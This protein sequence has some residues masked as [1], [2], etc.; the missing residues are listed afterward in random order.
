MIKNIR[1]LT[2]A[3]AI[4]MLAG[5]ATQPPA[6]VVNGRA[7]QRSSAYSYTPPAVSSQTTKPSM[8]I[9][10][11]G[12]TLSGIADKYNMTVD[13]L[14][15]ANNLSSPD[16]LRLGQKLKIEKPVKH[17]SLTRREIQEPLT[18][19]AEEV[20]PAAAQSGGAVSYTHHKVN[21]GENLFR[22]GL[23]YGVSPLDI[24][25]ENDIQTPE[26]LKAGTVL[27]IPV[28]VTKGV[29][30]SDERAIVKIN[31][32][33]AK[34]KGFIWP[35]R[36]KVLEGFGPKSA[37]IA[38]TGIKILVPENTQV[39]AAEQGTVIYADNGLSSY[40]N[41]ILLR[42]NN[43]LITAYAHNNKILVKRD[44]RVAKAQVIALSGKTG[45]V[46]RP[47]LHFEVRRRARA[48]DPMTVLP[49][50]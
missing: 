14:M 36:G 30:E 28:A 16:M 25:A 2:A 27:R 44:E 5:C 49:K 6:P 19:Q 21:A 17:Y 20:A 37:G 45:N 35:V 9:V 24:M 39:L 7:A 50:R 4:T 23:K 3:T 1:T 43:G 33:A 42:H 26:S 40:G 18:E 38:N 8:H 31:Q 29:S 10:Q 11:Q 12:D 46:D 47:Q 32:E 15:E 13:D 48:I 41:L 34:A 22:I